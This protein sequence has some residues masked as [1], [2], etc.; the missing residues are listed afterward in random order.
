MVSR[1]YSVTISQTTFQSVDTLRFIMVYESWD[2]LLQNVGMF[3]QKVY[4][5]SNTPVS[6]EVLGCEF[7]LHSNVVCS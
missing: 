7:L 6:E 2:P 5:A 3:T 4:H 1:S